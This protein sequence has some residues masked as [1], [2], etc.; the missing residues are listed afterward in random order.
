MAIAPSSGV[1]PVGRR[2]SRHFSDGRQRFGGASSAIDSKS[3]HVIQI[4]HRKLIIV[5]TYPLKGNQVFHLPR[6]LYT[7]AAVYNVVA[8]VILRRLFQP[9]CRICLHRH[10]C[11]NREGT[12]PSD[13]AKSTCLGE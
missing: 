5:D 9:N 12:H 6:L 7:L 4:T 13:A 11:P 2:T 8:V 3:F 10:T 1:G